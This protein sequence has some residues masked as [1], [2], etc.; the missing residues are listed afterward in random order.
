MRP[1]IPPWVRPNTEIC[2]HQ[3]PYGHFLIDLQQTNGAGCGSRHDHFLPATCSSHLWNVWMHCFMW[4]SATIMMESHGWGR[5]STV[6]SAAA[7]PL[8]PVGVSV[9]IW[10]ST[11]FRPRWWD[12]HS[13]RSFPSVESLNLLTEFIQAQH[14]SVCLQRC[15]IGHKTAQFKEIPTQLV[16]ET[17]QSGNV[18]CLCS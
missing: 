18:V 14:L 8:N 12:W 10:V 6:D 5:P 11:V 16:R 7:A 4:S 17:A 2:G 15:Q 3:E 13:R 9:S 1:I